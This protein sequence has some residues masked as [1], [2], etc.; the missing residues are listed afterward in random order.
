M[1]C[2]PF[3]GGDRSPNSPRVPMPHSM[4]RM[5]E[6]PGSSAR[7]VPLD[8]KLTNVRSL[9]IVG[10]L[11]GVCPSVWGGHSTTKVPCGGRRLLGTEYL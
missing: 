3:W 5:L 2:R 7:M 11:L 9:L 10:P 4:L 1:A 6:A 8:W